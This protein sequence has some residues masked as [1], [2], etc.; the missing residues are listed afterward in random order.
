MF[1]AFLWGT[2]AAAQPLI[3][4]PVSGTFGVDSTDTVTLAWTAAAN[5]TSYHIDVSEDPLFGS[6]LA[7]KDNDIDA[8]PNVLGQSYD[9]TFA[10]QN[11]T[12]KAGRP[13]YWRVTA[14]LDDGQHLTSTTAVF[15]TAADPFK[16]LADAGFALTRAEDGVDKDKPATLSFIRKGSDEGE[17]QYI[18][19]F[20]A[21]WQG[22]PFPSSPNTNSLFSPSA[23]AAGKLTNDS[24]DTDTLAKISVGIVNDIS[25][26]TTPISSVYQSL[27]A[28]YE[29]DQEFN[30]RKALLEYLLTYSNQRIGR[31][32]GGPSDR[33]QRLFRPYLGL[34][35]G[36]NVDKTDS[37]ET[38]KKIYRIA[39]QADLKFRLNA[40]SRRLGLASSLLSLS[41]KVYILPNEER[42]RHNFFTASLD[43]ELAKGFSVGI[44]FKNGHDAPKFEGVNTLALT[45][46]V[47]I[48]G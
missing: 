44:A 17:Q 9:I 41:D 8:K 36:R 33:F 3:S 22:K 13:Y 15:I 27:N 11:E 40:L 38:K 45:F 18:A 16:K 43:F 23:A 29:G 28:S 37:G 26:P 10:D 7:L 34:A 46:G 47:K 48:G 42:R 6:R 19:E 5:A 14:T 32:S 39:P 30:S 1:L 25:L 24:K 12:L 2:H 35:F 21:T 20:L 4:S 31:F